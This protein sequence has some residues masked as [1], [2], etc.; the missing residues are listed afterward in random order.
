MATKKPAAKKKRVEIDNQKLLDLAKKGIHQNEIMKQLGIKTSTQLKVAYANALME[1]GT[2]PKLQGGRGGGASGE[3]SKEVVVGKRG[4]IIIPRAL[5]EE[6]GLKE[7]EGFAVR[8]SKSGL[9][10]SK[11]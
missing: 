5:V 7:G 9:T 8:K 3:V 1:A 4:S 10:L 11:K 6:L 2:A